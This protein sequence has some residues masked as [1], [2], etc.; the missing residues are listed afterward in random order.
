MIL[1][2]IVSSDRPD[3]LALA[4]SRLGL[5]TAAREYLDGKL[6][7]FTVLLTGL[8]RVEGKWLKGLAEAGDAPGR[9]EFPFY[10]SG[11]QKK[12]PGT[13]MLSGP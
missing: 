3:D 5:P 10:V 9:E 11:D 6:P 1:A 4:Y 13:A 8:T 2:R 7:H 12:R